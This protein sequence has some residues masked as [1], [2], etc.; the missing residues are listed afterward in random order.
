MVNPRRGNGEIS[1]M[2]R[3]TFTKKLGT[4]RGRNRPGHGF[5]KNEKRPKY[6]ALTAK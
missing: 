1:F 6:D 3:F 2:F 4:Q 5:D